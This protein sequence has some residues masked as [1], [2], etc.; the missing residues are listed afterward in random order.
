MVRNRLK[1]LTRSAAL[2]GALTLTHSVTAFAAATGENTPLNLGSGQSSAVHVGSSGSGMGRTIIGL[3]IVVALIYGISWLMRRAKRNSTDK[4]RGT[5][6]S[7]VASLPL[8]SGRSVQIVRAGTDLLVLGVAEHGVTKLERY[9]EEDARDAGL[10]F[11][12]NEA[13]VSGDRPGMFDGLRRLTVRSDA[14][15]NEQ[16][17]RPGTLEVLRNL[18]A[19]SHQTTD[20]DSHAAA[21]EGS[22]PR[23]RLQTLRQLTVRS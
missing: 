23:T 2:A 18:T 6:L 14:T 7:S 9:T 10:E 1:T 12:A 17:K 5:A 16:P 19:R 21:D 22:R 15:A 13:A 3:V 4:A 11:A 8:G 20:E